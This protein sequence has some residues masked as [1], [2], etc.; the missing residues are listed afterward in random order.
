[1]NNRTRYFVLGSVAVIAAGLCTGLVA[2][3]GGFPTGAAARNSAPDEL[4]YVPS[5]SS[6]VAYANVREVM[7]SQFRQR[8]K[9][10]VPD[11]AKGQEEFERETGI[12]IENDVDYI[13]ACMLAETQG[14]SGALVLAKG[15]FDAVRLEGIA[16]QHG[17]IV[18]DYKGKRIIAPKGKDGD[19]DPALAFLE[20]GLVAVGT[21]PAVRRAIDT[22]A[23]NQNITGNREIMDLMGDLQGGGNAWAVGRFDVLAS[24]AHLPANVA[25]QLPSIKYFAASGR[26][27]GG[28][29]GTFRAETRDDK[30]AENLRDVVRGFMA[31]AKMQVGSNPQLQPLVDSVQLGGSGS[32]V[33]ISFSVQPEVLDMIAPRKPVGGDR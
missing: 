19:Q 5:D 20:A 27:N 18:S 3:Y 32:T 2:Y 28:V 6:V 25:S 12:S 23:S 11:E 16:R 31:L 14:H 7:T 9:D 10:V 29:S 17:G 26:I 13:V 21:E 24:Q 1:M 15:R 30:S 22:A 33:A 8:L 4:R